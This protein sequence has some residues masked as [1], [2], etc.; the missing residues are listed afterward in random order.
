M[1]ET[2]KDKTADKGTGTVLKS[3]MN[4]ESLFEFGGEISPFLEELFAFLSDLM[5]ILAKAQFS[6][7][8]STKHMPDA[9]DNIASAE[10][11]SEDAT[12]TIM[13]NLEG[14]TAD[15]EALNSSNLDAATQAKLDTLGDKITEIQMALQFQDIT[16]QHLRQ[17]SQIVEAIQVRMS[18]LFEALQSIGEKNELVKAI[19]DNY[20]QEVG[21]EDALDQADKIR[22]DDSVSQADIDALFGN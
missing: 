2:K 11:L 5:P 17:A 22:R 13:D 7:R 9:S 6:L 12:N 21:D 19:V 4:L 18:K 14:I 10:T 3:L 15:L 1:S 8:D 20:A 16:A